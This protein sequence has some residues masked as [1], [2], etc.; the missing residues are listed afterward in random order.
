M[1]QL[2]VLDTIFQNLGYSTAIFGEFRWSMGI[3]SFKFELLDM[4][5]DCM[6]GFINGSGDFVGF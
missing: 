6:P 3:I 5:F 2:V 1:F 4:G